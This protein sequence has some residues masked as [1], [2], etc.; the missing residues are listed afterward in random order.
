MS[1]DLNVPC[2]NVEERETQERKSYQCV[3]MVFPFVVV[4]TDF[5]KAFVQDASL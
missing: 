2:R 4:F 5:A 3:D 1:L